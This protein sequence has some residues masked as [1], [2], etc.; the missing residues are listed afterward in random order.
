MLEVAR[1]Y[2]KING[3]MFHLKTWRGNLKMCNKKQILSTTLQWWEGVGAY[4]KNSVFK[5]A[6]LSLVCFF[7]C[8]SPVLRFFCRFIF[9]PIFLPFSQAPIW[10]MVVLMPPLW[11]LCSGALKWNYWVRAEEVWLWV[12]FATHGG[13]FRLHFPG[14]FCWLKRGITCPQDTDDSIQEQLRLQCTITGLTA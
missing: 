13:Q 7:L 8:R 5:G 1:D 2:Q 11:K 10:M 9:G 12:V 6:K 14:Y 3:G 4:T